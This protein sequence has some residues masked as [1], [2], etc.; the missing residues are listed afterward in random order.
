MVFSH[1]QNH[2]AQAQQTALDFARQTAALLPDFGIGRRPP[3][4]ENKQE[5]TA[6]DFRSE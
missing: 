4:P 2:P 1:L 3:Q 5:T 6:L